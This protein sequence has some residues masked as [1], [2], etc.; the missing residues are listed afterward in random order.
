MPAG[1]GNRSVKGT[2]EGEG[3]SAGKL[4]KLNRESMRP[5][6]GRIGGLVVVM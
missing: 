2:E 1:A 3:G 4:M 6:I 5:A